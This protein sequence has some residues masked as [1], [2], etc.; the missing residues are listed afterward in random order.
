LDEKTGNM[1]FQDLTSYTYAIAAISLV[2]IWRAWRSKSLPS[3]IEPEALTGG[4]KGIIF[5]GVSRD[6]KG[7]TLKVAH[8]SF[9]K[10]R[11]QL[12]PLII[13]LSSPNPVVPPI[14]S[15]GSARPSSNR[16]IWFFP[17]GKLI[18]TVHTIVHTLRL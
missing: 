13:K 4:F 10:V 3:P 11:P 15:P 17:S 16:G 7:S 8:N 18:L 14:V 2:I 6:L 12:G 1:I 5:K 9:F